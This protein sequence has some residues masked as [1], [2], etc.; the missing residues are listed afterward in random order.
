M[1]F[2]NCRNVGS[3]ISA[4]E[5]SEKVMREKCKRKKHFLTFE[6]K[7]IA[8]TNLRKQNC[9]FLQFIASAQY[10]NFYEQQLNL[11]RIGYCFISSLARM[12]VHYSI[13]FNFRSVYYSMYVKS[14]EF[15]F[16]FT[17]PLN[18]SR[19]IETRICRQ[20]CHRAIIARL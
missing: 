14:V 19:F 8:R 16:S 18:W 12:F 15:F 9:T 3:I 10:N 1:V 5:T 17:Y 13:D 2:K 4:V 20:H 6:M 11:R 7:T